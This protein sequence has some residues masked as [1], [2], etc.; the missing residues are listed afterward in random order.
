MTQQHLAGRNLNLNLFSLLPLSF[1]VRE[2]QSCGG[3]VRRSQGLLFCH[4]VA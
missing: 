2:W 3:W 1:P 4:L